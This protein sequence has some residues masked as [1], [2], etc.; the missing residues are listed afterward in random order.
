MRRCAV[1]VVLTALVVVSAVAP[2]GAQVRIRRCP[3]I[4]PATSVPMWSI[5]ARGIS[6]A[7]VRPV[8]LASMRH[9]LSSGCRLAGGWRCTLWFQPNPTVAV[10]TRCTR[11]YRHQQFTFDYGGGAGAE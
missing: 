5:R 2:A 10:H 8:V 9:C 6:C 3:D 4:R 11:A 1:L 7:A